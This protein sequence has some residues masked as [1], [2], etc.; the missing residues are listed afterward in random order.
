VTVG[1]IT[2]C[3]FLALFDFPISRGTATCPRLIKTR[4]CKRKRQATITLCAEGWPL[5]FLS[6]SSLPSYPLSF[7]LHSL[8][9][10]SHPI[11][12]L[13]LLGH[14]RILMHLRLSKRML[15][16]PLSQHFADFGGG[17][18]PLT[19]VNMALPPHISFL[20]IGVGAQ[21][22]LGGTACLPQ[23]TMCVWKINKMSEF[24]TI[25]A[26][27]IIKIPEFLLYLP[28]KLTKFPN[29]TRFSSKNS[30]ILHNNCPK[31]ICPAR[32]RLL[33]LCCSPSLPS[34][35]LRSPPSHCPSLCNCHCRASASVYTKLL[36]RFRNAS[37]SYRRCRMLTVEPVPSIRRI[38]RR[39][40]LSLKQ[41]DEWR[42]VWQL[43]VDARHWSPPLLPPNL[44]L[45]SAQLSQCR[46]DA[47][48]SLAGAF[49][50]TRSWSRRANDVP[51]HADH[52]TTPQTRHIRPGPYLCRISK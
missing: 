31:N 51:E 28:E 24:Y 14:I 9:F 15:W 38:R 13:S 33:R 40:V 46:L 5:C 39:P 19:F 49:M 35:H 26:R 11:L 36:L 44:H 7:P 30:R 10:P 34:L 20:F 23:N 48:V 12:T 2:F 3:D 4:S 47:I 41:S 17:W 21:S 43:A 16:K 50:S 42:H 1:N 25:L 45:V 27:K 32:P 6:L 29:F 52:V 8:L 37:K 22:T 18:S